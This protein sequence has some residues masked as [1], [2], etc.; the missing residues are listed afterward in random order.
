MALLFFILFL[1]CAQNKPLNH[2]PSP[3]RSLIRHPTSNPILHLLSLVPVPSLPAIRSRGLESQQVQLPH[4]S[5]VPHSA[6]SIIPPNSSNTPMSFANAAAQS[7]LRST[8]PNSGLRTVNSSTILSRSSAGVTTGTLR[9]SRSIASLNPH[10]SNSPL[11]E[12]SAPK[13]QAINN[14]IGGNGGSGSYW[15]HSWYK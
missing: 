1:G 7:I 15:E 11:S 10:Q 3:R 5:V 8:T 4:P 14:T 13:P 2:H 9:T 12:S 6:G